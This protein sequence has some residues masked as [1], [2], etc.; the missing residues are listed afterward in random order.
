M[1][2]KIQLFTERIS[3][4]EFRGHFY[5]RSIGKNVV[6]LATSYIY[7]IFIRFLKEIVK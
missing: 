3:E 2:R 5:V 4:L 6:N 7:Q 1:S